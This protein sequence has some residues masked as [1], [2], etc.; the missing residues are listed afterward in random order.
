MSVAAVESSLLEV[1]D[2]IDLDGCKLVGPTSGS[3]GCYAV[4]HFGLKRGVLLVTAHLDDADESVAMLKDLDVDVELF[5]ALESESSNE[6]IA[7]RY[8]ILDRMAS[9]SMPTVIVASI[10][11]LMQMTPSPNEVGNVVRRLRAGDSCSMSNL[12]QWLVDGGYERREN[13]FDWI[14]LGT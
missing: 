2:L 7:A 9:E 14:F 12:Q 11:A 13:L 10:P 8:A 5:P 6:L 3:F 1:A 4:A